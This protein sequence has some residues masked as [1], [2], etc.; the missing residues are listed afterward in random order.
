MPT[1]LIDLFRS[2]NIETTLTASAVVGLI[3]VLVLSTLVIASKSAQTRKTNNTQTKSIP[4][5]AATKPP[6]INPLAA[7]VDVWADRLAKGVA[8]ASLNH[9]RGAGE[10]KPF[11]SSYY[12]AHNNSKTT[13]GYKD[14]LRMEDY[15]MNGP[16]L[17]SRLITTTS[18]DV[19]VDD[20]RTEENS[21]DAHAYPSATSRPSAPDT[22]PIQ[23]L[24]L[25]KTSSSSAKSVANTGT[26]QRRR[27]VLLPISKY[28]FDDSQSFA[29]IRIDQ[30]PVHGDGR[31]RLNNKASVLDWKDVDVVEF[32]SELIGGHDDGKQGLLVIVTTGTDVDYQLHI[33]TLFASVINVQTTVPKNNKRLLVKLCKKHRKDWPHP[34]AMK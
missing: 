26:Q 23:S 13:G 7:P 19:L 25:E 29:T 22:E 3:V 31:D 10:E 18:D 17:L 20:D 28:L 24:P 5:P 2:E 34:H 8:P 1:S 14:G 12:Y 16:R 15:T 9:K 11:A 6:I 27:R 21:S 30:L 32:K 4:S 33:R